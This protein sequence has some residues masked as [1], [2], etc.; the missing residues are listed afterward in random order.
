MLDTS[1][2]IPPRASEPGHGPRPVHPQ[3]PTGLSAGRAMTAAAGLPR[4]RRLLDRLSRWAG[5]ASAGH[6][7]RVPF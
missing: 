6:Q 3:Q 1:V 5:A 7:D 4:Q 2:S